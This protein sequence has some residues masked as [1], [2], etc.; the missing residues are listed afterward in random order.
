MIN[1]KKIKCNVVA[2]VL[3]ANISIWTALALL[4][5]MALMKCIIRVYLVVLVGHR[6]LY[7]SSIESGLR[8]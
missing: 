7:L 3:N 6:Q 8:N 4:L 1:Y 2:V 5:Q